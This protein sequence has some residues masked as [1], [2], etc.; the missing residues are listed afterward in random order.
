MNPLRVVILNPCIVT[1]PLNFRK[2][3]RDKLDH[4]EKANVV[5]G[6]RVTGILFLT[7]WFKGSLGAKN[8]DKI[9]KS[10]LLKRPWIENFSIVS[11]EL[12]LSDEDAQEFLEN[13][14]NDYRIQEQ[15][16]E[17]DER[18]PMPEVDTDEIVDTLLGYLPEHLKEDGTLD[19]TIEPI[20]VVRKVRES[21]FTDSL[22][23]AEGYAQG[24]WYVIG[25]DESRE[26]V[27][28]SQPFETEADA[29]DFATHEHGT[30]VFKQAA[31]IQLAHLQEQIETL[32]SQA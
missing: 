23:D 11:S 16:R 26:Q 1:T 4:Y 8:L 5:K 2:W 25:M 32:A 21:D 3:L 22:K 28:R 31:E 10:A 15:M 9:L 20:C 30:S 27:L 24:Q 18:D 13:V 7:K 17:L 12:P 19:H 14:Q 6:E 29:T